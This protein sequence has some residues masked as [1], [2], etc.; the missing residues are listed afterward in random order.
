MPDLMSELVG[1][2]MYSYYPLGEYVVRAP[3]VCAGRPTFKYTRIEIEG[4]LGR[5][6][7]GESIE[8]LVLG[9]RGRVTAE[10]ITEA[11]HLVT[12]GYINSLPELQPA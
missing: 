4:T 6:A 5:L 2:E 1:G 10:A 3:D 7:S 8:Q 9:Y 11:V 12:N